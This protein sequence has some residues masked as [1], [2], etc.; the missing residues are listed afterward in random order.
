MLENAYSAGRMLASKIAYS[1]RLILSAELIQAYPI[2]LFFGEGGWGAEGQRFLM[3][4][5]PFWYARPGKFY[6]CKKDSSQ[7]INS[8]FS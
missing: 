7:Q 8:I 3:H 6:F 4:L 1:G 2:C 5:L